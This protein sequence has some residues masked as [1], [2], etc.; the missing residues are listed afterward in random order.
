MA[1]IE[2]QYLNHTELVE[3]DTAIKQWA[4]DEISSSLVDFTGA[5]SST[6][7][8]AGQVPAPESGD[9][10]KFLRGDGS[11]AVVTGSDATNFI[12]TIEQWNAL[13]PERQAEYK[14]KD[15]TNDFN[16]YNIDSVVT[17]NSTNVITSGGVWSYV[18]SMITQALTASY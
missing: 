5:T 14:S 8:A 1:N 11:W 3:Y 13:S 12:G 6:D 2:K 16:G 7:G 9:A 4:Q 15:I 18:N 17:Q 10:E